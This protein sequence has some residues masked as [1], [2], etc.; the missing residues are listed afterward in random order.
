MFWKFSLAKQ[1]CNS[2]VHCGCCNQ[3]AHTI[4]NPRQNRNAFNTQRTSVVDWKTRVHCRI[5]KTRLGLLVTIYTICI[6]KCTYAGRGPRTSHYILYKMIQANTNTHRSPLLTSLLALVCF[7]KNLVVQQDRNRMPSRTYVRKSACVPCSAHMHV[8]AHRAVTTH[9]SKLMYSLLHQ[10]TWIWIVC[11]GE[12]AV[13]CKYNASEKAFE[14]HAHIDISD[15]VWSTIKVVGG[16]HCICL[17]TLRPTR[18]G[19]LCRCTESSNIIQRDRKC[20]R[21]RISSSS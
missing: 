19:A 12:H 13:L 5:R 21:I 20:S 2:Q 11:E 3:N 8:Y 15:G 17:R 9:D 7:N 18:R 4:F 16:C 14:V 1:P 10:P 6:W